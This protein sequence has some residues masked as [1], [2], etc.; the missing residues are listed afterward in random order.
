MSDTQWEKVRSGWKQLWD[1]WLW[2]E[3]W[4]QQM[5]CN[6]MKASL[7]PVTSPSG[8]EQWPRLMGQGLWPPTYR[9]MHA[10][11]HTCTYTFFR[12]LHL[13]WSGKHLKIHLE[14]NPQQ[15]KYRSPSYLHLSL[16]FMSIFFQMNGWNNQLQVMF[17]VV[18][19]WQ[20]PLSPAC[21]RGLPFT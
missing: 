4:S 9:Q 5:S 6:L 7:L 8:C 16:H 19:L 13:M 14:P 10:H 21:V 18:T 15:S 11:K 20:D 12:S 17:A 2:K 1:K 3:R